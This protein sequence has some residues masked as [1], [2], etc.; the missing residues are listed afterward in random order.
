ML[1]RRHH[2]VVLS[3]EDCDRLF[4]WIDLN[5]P[6]HGTWSDVYPIPGGVH[7]GQ[8]AMWAMAGGALEDPE[9]IPPAEPYRPEPIPHHPKPPQIAKSVE[10]AA[11]NEGIRPQVAADAGPTRDTVDLGDG[12][13]LELVHIPGDRVR[14]GADLV[15]TDQF[16]P[17]MVKAAPFWMS[18]CE[19]PNEP[20]A[21]FDP[22]HS[23]RYD[24]KRHARED[25]PGLP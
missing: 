14:M 22:A 6:C 12:T 2:G 19:I 8:M 18:I 13:V 24:A 20:F 25:E 16:P 1:R 5:A 21:R 23:S 17:T 11:R 15:G 4:T 9:Q 3:G 7:Q 10:A